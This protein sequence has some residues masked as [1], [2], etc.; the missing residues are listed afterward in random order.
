M[1]HW[2]LGLDLEHLESKRIQ[3]KVSPL[4]SYSGKKSA[5]TEDQFDI[6]VNIF[7]P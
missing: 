5:I 7:L 1:R 6:A 4:G 2:V 3:L